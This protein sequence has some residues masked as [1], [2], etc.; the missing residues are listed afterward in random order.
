MRKCSA[1]GSS[2]ASLATAHPRALRD[3]RCERSRFAFAEA[4][5]DA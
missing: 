1:G 5:G 3:V 4:V 2:V